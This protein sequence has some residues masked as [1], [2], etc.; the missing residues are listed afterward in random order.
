MNYRGLQGLWI[1]QLL[2]DG[3]G[4]GGVREV[5]RGEAVFQCCQ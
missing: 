3:G 4:G 1:G 5:V 2:T